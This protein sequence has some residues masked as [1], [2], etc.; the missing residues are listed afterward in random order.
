MGD[1]KWLETIE[2]SG[3][4]VGEDL[5]HT[6]GPVA[7]GRIIKFTESGG[8]CNQ[9]GII[10]TS[11][12]PADADVPEVR[13]RVYSS[14]VDCVV[15]ARQREVQASPVSG[16]SEL[17]SIVNESQGAWSARGVIARVGA[18]EDDIAHNRRTPD[19]LGHIQEVDIVD[20]T[21]FR[22][23][24][25]DGFVVFKVGS[26]HGV[27]FIRACDMGFFTRPSAWRAQVLSWGTPTC[28]TQDCC[29]LGIFLIGQ[30]IVEEKVFGYGYS[31]HH[32]QSNRGE[33]TEPHGRCW[34]GRQRMVAN[35][36]NEMG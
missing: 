36:G 28:V 5:V 29:C 33:P 4:V 35:D 7:K 12:L 26:G 1:G 9:V 20:D 19:G 17:D 24:N 2:T 31:S 11:Q 23:R 21:T 22:I 13:Q 16:R 6:T 34:E 30:S 15:V 18:D 3:G 14:S 10:V 25:D 8:V 32:S 27:P